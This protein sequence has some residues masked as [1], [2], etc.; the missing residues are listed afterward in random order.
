LMRL[1]DICTT[2]SDGGY[3]VANCGFPVRHD[4]DAQMNIGD[5]LYA[6]LYAML[7]ESDVLK[8]KFNL[9][10]VE[11]FVNKINKLIDILV[12]RRHHRYQIIL[13]T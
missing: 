5:I 11:G 10:D 8:N 9:N 6:I 12:K 2:E 13:L 4:V 1:G 7:F 3:Y